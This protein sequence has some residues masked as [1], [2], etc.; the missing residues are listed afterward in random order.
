VLHEVLGDAGLVDRVRVIH[1]D[2]TAVDWASEFNEPDAT[3]HVV[4]NLPTTSPPALSA[5]CSPMF[6]PSPR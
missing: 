5:T 1:A 3:L 6:L 4:A 2:A